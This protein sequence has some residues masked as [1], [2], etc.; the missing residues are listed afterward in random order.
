[1]FS[2]IRNSC[3]EPLLL[4]H[5]SSGGDGSSCKDAKARRQCLAIAHTST[6]VEQIGSKI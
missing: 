2:T 3:A 5:P 1:M 4:L 6:I